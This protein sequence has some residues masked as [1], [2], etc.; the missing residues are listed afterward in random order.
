MAQEVVTYSYDSLGRLVTVTH[1]GGGNNGVATHYTYDRAGNRT[2]VVTSGVTGNPGGGGE[3]C[4]VIIGDTAT[5]PYSRYDGPMV[6]YINRSGVCASPTVINYSTRDDTAIGGVSYEVNNGT[7]TMT[8]ASAQVV[9]EVLPGSRSRQRFYLDVTVV[10]GG[11]P[12]S[13][14][15][16]GVFEVP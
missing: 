7:L 4:T 5:L 2:A 10:S 15:A 16:M 6:F 12:S 8:G 1:A 13:L 3:D 11:A 14:T 9:S